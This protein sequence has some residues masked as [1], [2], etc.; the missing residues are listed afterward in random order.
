MRPKGSTKVMVVQETLPVDMHVALGF[1][2][3]RIARV[4]REYGADCIERAVVAHPV[5][6]MSS[7]LN[8]NAVFQP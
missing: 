4:I 7:T 3:D 2:D 5:K 6:W 8:D 1:D